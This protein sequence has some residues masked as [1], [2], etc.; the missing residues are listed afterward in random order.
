MI[1]EHIE[2]VSKHTTT[3]QEIEGPRLKKL[4]QRY[5]TLPNFKVS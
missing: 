3:A 4:I 1:K 5:Y 2:E